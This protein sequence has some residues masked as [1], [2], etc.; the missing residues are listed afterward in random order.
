VERVGKRDA[1]EGAGGRLELAGPSILEQV[2]QI[3]AQPT[4]RCCRAFKG[5]RTGATQVALMM[6]T[7][8]SRVYPSKSVP[9]TLAPLRFRLYKKPRCPPKT[10]L[11]LPMFRERRGHQRMAICEAQSV[12]RILR[13]RGAP[14][15]GSTSSAIERVGRG[16]GGP[17]SRTDLYCRGPRR[18][19]NLRIGFGRACETDDIVTTLI[20]TSAPPGNPKGCGQEADTHQSAVRGPTKTRWERGAL[21]IE[22]GATGFR[23][24]LTSAHIAT[25]GNRPCT[26]RRC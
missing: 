16:P 21:G 22:F 3:V 23:V 8:G 2:E 14:I 5:V 1:L 18:P 4:A 13:Q 12:D 20:Y 9:N 15:R 7:T 25:G 26:A 19:S 10:N 6:G 11:N 17:L 24:V